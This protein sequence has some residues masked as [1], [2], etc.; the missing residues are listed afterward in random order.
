MKTAKEGEGERHSCTRVRTP[1]GHFK[2]SFVLFVPSADVE[3]NISKLVPGKTNW[4]GMHFKRNPGAFIFFDNDNSGRGISRAPNSNRSRQAATSV[5]RL[6]GA[7]A[8]RN[9]RKLWR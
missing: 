3:D 4:T 2:S 8:A 6:N 9:K 5:Q 7:H 1:D